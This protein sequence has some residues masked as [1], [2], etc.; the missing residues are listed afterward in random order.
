MRLEHDDFVAAWG[1]P[2]FS[3]GSHLAEVLLRR[4]HRVHGLDDLS[5]GSIENIRHLK[6]G[7]GFSHDRLTGSPLVA[8]LVDEADAICHRAAAVGVQLVVESPV[9]TIETNVNCT[10]VVLSQ[11]GD[12]TQRRWFCRVQDVVRALAGLMKRDDL[13]GEVLN[14]GSTEEVTI[15][16]LAQRVKGLSGSRSEIV[17]IPYEKGFEDMARRVPDT[18][19]IHEAIG[20]QP[21]QSLSGILTDV[22]AR[23]RSAALGKLVGQAA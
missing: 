22:I 5:T 15:L 14:I 4:G 17:A 8:E 9:R 6:L 20:W 12:G 21:T 23:E 1:E 10:E 13:F 18:T 7:L 3:I 16:D 2:A 19:K 11:F